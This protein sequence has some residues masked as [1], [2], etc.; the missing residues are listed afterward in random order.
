MPEGLSEGTRTGEYGDC[1]TIIVLLFLA[2][3]ARTSNDI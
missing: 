1:G 2:K 3:Y